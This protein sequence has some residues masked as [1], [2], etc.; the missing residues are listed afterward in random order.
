MLGCALFFV[1]LVFCLYRRQI[2]DTGVRATFVVERDIVPERSSQI[3]HVGISVTMSFLYFQAGKEGFHW[4]V[5]IG[6]TGSRKRLLHSILEKQSSEFV[7]RILGTSVAMKKQVGG[8]A[9]RLKCV[10]EC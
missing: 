8:V 5:V 3:T 4:S 10:P 1:I 7:G 6:N 9:S 2:S